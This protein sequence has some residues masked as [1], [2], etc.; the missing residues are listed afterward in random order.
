MS[1]ADG[2]A[3]PRTPGALDG[4]L[5]ADF[6]R[7]LAGPYATMLLADLGAEVVKIERPDTGDDT[8]SWGPPWVGEGTDREAT[9]FLSVNR[10]KKS[11]AL[12]LTTDAGLDAARDLVTRADVVVENFLPGTMDRLGLGYEQ[13]RELNEDIVYCSVTGFGGQSDLAGYDLLIQAVGGLMSVTGPDPR[14]PTKV[15]VAVVDVVTGL[16]ATVGILAALRHRDRTGEGQRVE[17]ALLSSLLSALVNQTSGYLAAGIVPRAMGNRHPSITPYEVFPTADRPLVLAVGNDRQFAALVH[18]LGLPDLATDERYA[19]NA[20]RV[21]HRDELAAL[22]ERALAARAADDWFEALTAKRVPCGPLNDIADAF[23]LAERL[24][25]DATATIEDPRRDA[26][27]LQAANPIRLSA[28]P[29]TYRCAP[30]RL[31]EDS[32]P[33]PG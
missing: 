27:I 24:G 5:V 29:A 4:L 25:L 6:G 8:R 10:N 14:T 31:G 2:P 30:P 20:A 33:G 15:G 16:H 18:V 9:Y 1:G 28:T 19:T 22:L 12:D 7:V 26:P 23:A 13:V 32:A 3:T 17:V 11:V 21:A